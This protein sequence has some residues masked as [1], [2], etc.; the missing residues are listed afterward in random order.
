MINIITTYFIALI[1][2]M[3]INMVYAADP[4]PLQDFCIALVNETH[5]PVAVNGFFCKRQKDVKSTDFLFQGYNTPLNTN[6]R[7]GA[8][9][10]MINVF[11]FP[12]VNTLG[13]ALGRIDFAPGGVNPIHYHPRSS[14]M[15]TV[16]H[17]T[18]FAGFVTSNL[19]GENEVN[20]LYSAVL[21]EGDI[22]V[23]PQGLPH[24][25]LNLG[26]KPAVANAAFGSQ[27]PGRVDINRAV[28]GSTPR[29]PD[30]VLLRSFQI[31]G[32]VL[33]AL[34]AQFSESRE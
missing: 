34:R 25:Q 7:Y 29:I 15:F 21:N 31:D 8:A 4:N 11:L 3:S 22:F 23:F 24:F 28:F 27:N 6:N 9:S 2:I 16:L 33:E 30:P 32:N 19:P 1:M 5:L 13:I 10:R 20:K 17:G 26:N 14:E 12:A 18:V